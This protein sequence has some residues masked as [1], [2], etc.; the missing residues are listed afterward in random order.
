ML[1][2]LPFADLL[3]SPM[4]ACAAISICMTIA[5]RLALPERVIRQL[6]WKRSWLTLSLFICYLAATV[7][8]LSGDLP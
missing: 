4:A 6:I 7:A 1:R 2:E 3:F 5:T 8:F